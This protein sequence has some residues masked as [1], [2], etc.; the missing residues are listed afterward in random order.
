VHI[1]KA[2][3]SQIADEFLSI[4]AAAGYDVALYANI[5]YLKNYF[6]DKVK[7]KYPL[8]LAAYRD[9]EP[10]HGQV[11]WQHTERGRVDGIRGAVDLNISNMT[12]VNKRPTAGGDDTV[13]ISL[14]VLRRGA[15]GNTVT[16]VQQLLAAK[17]YKSG[18]TDGI[19]GENTEAAVKRFQAAK[20]LTADGIVG[21]NTYIKLLK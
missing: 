15:K 8:W 12:T 5:D 10:S 7:R 16:A 14:P 1:T 20:G 9:T 21:K 3:A 4:V 13:N 17:G 18:K 6:T 11:I 2:L 19:F